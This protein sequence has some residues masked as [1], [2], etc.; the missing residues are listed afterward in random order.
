[1]DNQCNTGGNPTSPPAW[2]KTKPHV[3]ALAVG[4]HTHSQGKMYYQP[5]WPHT[6]LYI[7]TLIGTGQPCTTTDTIQL[8]E[9]SD[10][11]PSKW[12]HPWSINSTP[13][14]K[15]EE[16]WHTCPRRPG[17]NITIHIYAC[18]EK[19]E[20]GTWSLKYGSPGPHPKDE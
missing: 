8:T 18:K 1:M 13:R 3:P 14:Y 4:D 5:V 17:L 12:G 2:T 7:R 16:R 10:L 11:Y 20:L 19:I 9:S 15:K 6:G